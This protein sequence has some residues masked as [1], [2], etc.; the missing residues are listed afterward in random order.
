MCWTIT[1]NVNYRIW[2]NIYKNGKKNIK[3]ENKKVANWKFGKVGNLGNLGKVIPSFRF[4]P[5]AKIGNSNLKVSEKI[6]W[7]FQD[8]LSFRVFDLACLGSYWNASCLPPNWLRNSD[9]LFD[10]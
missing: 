2:E 5:T 1:T 7:D 3:K 4:W 8:I 6:F 9:W 10:Q